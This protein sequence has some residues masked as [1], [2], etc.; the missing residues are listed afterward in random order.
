MG[1]KV[2]DAH[3]HIC[4]DD[5]RFGIDLV[6]SWNDLKDLFTSG[7]LDRA[8][9]MPM[10]SNTEDSREVNRVFFE[11]LQRQEHKDSIWAYYWPHP[12]EVDFE[13]AARDN[14]AGIKFHPSIS[15]VTIDNAP[16]VVK[17][18]RDNGKPL[19][20]H[21]GR[22]MKSRI[23]YLLT[24]RRKEPDG[25]YIAAH[26]GG[27]ANELIL[28]ALD[29]IDS[30]SN[31]DGLYLDTSGCMNPKIMKRAIDVMGEDQILWGTDLPFFNLDISRYVLSKT[32]INDSTIKK[33]LYDNVVKVHKS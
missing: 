6:F 16:D 8:L 29:R 9:V 24:V 14:V 4:E 2:A 17:A 10:L 11:E 1:F 25:T 31:I 33:I 18:A 3:I 21:S 7:Q 12:N 13:F 26:L 15:Q 20:V 19:L 22:N 5:W 32:D 27:L 30:L 28:A 23:E